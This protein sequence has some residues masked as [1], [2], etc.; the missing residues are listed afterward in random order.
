MHIPDGFLD[1]KTLAVTNL[2]SV[3]FL[4]YAV[5]KI[6][7]SIT[8]DRIP[9]MGICAVFVFTLQLFTFPVIGG[10][11][12]HLLGSVLISVLLG[13]LSGL[14]VVSSALILQALLFQHG[15]IICI[16]ANILNIG[17]VGCMLGYIIYKIFPTRL[18]AAIACWITV[19]LGSVL[20][21]VEMFFS[22]KIDLKYGLICM[23]STHAV[24]GLVEAIATFS[25]LSAIYMIRPDIKNITKI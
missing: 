13:P 20:C 4:T 19:V 6:N 16:G 25:I 9:L 23:L 14:L 2:T 1:I 12:I 21:A 22:G 11:S 15:G 18:L 3:V 8:P 7:K 24:T 17:I 5:R 10:T